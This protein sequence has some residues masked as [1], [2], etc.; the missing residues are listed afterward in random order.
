MYDCGSS[1]VAT[2]ACKAAPLLALAPRLH[3]FS[4]LTTAG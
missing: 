4:Q 1:A 3:A 2:L